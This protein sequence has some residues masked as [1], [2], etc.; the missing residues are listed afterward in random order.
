MVWLLPVIVIGGLFYPILGLIVTGMII[1]FSILSFFKQRYWCWYLC[2]RGA[3]LQMALPFVSAK[4]PL[5]RFM[6]QEW[7][8]WVVFVTLISYLVF[9][10]IRAGLNPV[11]IGAAFVGMCILTTIIGV[12]L[13]VVYKPRSWCVICPMGL[14]Q[15]KIGQLSTVNSRRSTVNN[16]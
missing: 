11:A 7:F 4:R 14:M 2:P 5:P 16:D 13:G 12:I 8:R 10:L 15:E 6:G 9:N 1:F 3:F